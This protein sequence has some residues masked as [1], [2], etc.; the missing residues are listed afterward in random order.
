M[1]SE[2]L[3]RIAVEPNGPGGCN[4]PPIE[5]GV[6]RVTRI[7]SNAPNIE[8]TFDPPNATL[9]GADFCTMSDTDIEALPDQT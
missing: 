5:V 1:E 6:I 2:T 9:L 4:G 8:R 7:R 3:V